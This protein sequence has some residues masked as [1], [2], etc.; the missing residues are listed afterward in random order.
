MTNSRALYT[1]HGG[2]GRR[3]AD[4]LPQVYEQLKHLAASKLSQEAPGQTLQA[5][6]LVHEAYMR[7]LRVRDPQHWNSSGHFF[8]SA[9]EAMRR[10]LIERA[11]R[12]RHRKTLGTYDDCEPIE[13]APSHQLDLLALDEA[14]AKLEKTDRRKADL[15]KLR[16]FGG[17]TIPQAA[18]VLGI[19][20]STA[21]NDWAYAKT[22][23]RREISK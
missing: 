14:L 21:D 6:A 22:W 13:D 8:S 2:E 3:C 20:T 4:Y 18:L 11:R 9:A 10:I 15:I 16:F 1:T 23:L 17:L 7:L 5:T 19:S 12:K